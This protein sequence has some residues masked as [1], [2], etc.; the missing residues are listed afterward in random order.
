M[1]TMMGTSELRMNTFSNVASITREDANHAFSSGNAER[2]C[3]ALVS[4]TFHDPDLH[5]VQDLC[6]G[7]LENGDSRI[8]GLAATCLGHLARIH[9]S[10]D[11]ERLLDVLRQHLSDAEIAGRIEDAIDDIQTFG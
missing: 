1:I 10:I 3:S 2:I 4:V 6:L 8:R 5:W 9:L 11:K 7:F